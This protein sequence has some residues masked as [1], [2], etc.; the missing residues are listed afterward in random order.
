MQD[1]RDEGKVGNIPPIIATNNARPIPIGAIKVSLLFSAASIRTTN[2]SS[3]VIKASMK[4]PCA[5][6]VSGDNEVLVAATLPGNIHCTNP[7]ALIAARSC[8]GRRKSP[9]SGGSVPPST[10]P[11]VTFDIVSI[12]ASSQ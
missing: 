8:A 3:A 2:T 4:T 9:R 11:S 12:R 5:M 1:R 10:K 6:L 7:P